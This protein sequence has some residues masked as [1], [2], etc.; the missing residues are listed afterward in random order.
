MEKSTECDEF[1][2]KFTF[3]LPDQREICVKKLAVCA[4]IVRTYPQVARIR[5]ERLEGVM[6]RSREKMAA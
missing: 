5:F 6:P 4:E 2:V 3:V 1:F